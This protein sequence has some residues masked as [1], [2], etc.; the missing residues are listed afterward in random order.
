MRYGEIVRAVARTWLVLGAFLTVPLYAFDSGPEPSGDEGP[1]EARKVPPWG[2]DFTAP[3]SPPNEHAM[4]F[5]LALA[6]SGLPNTLDVTPSNP[7]RATT[8]S[9]GS[10]IDGGMTSLVPSALNMATT[11]NIRS[12]T[13]AGFAS[14]PDHSY[15]LGDWASGNEL[16]PPGTA[17]FN[18]GAHECHSFTKHLGPVNSTHFPPQADSMY[19][20][21][22]SLAL[23][24]AGAC[25]ELANRFT[26]STLSSENRIEAV[27]MVREC[28]REA[29][30]LEA[31]GQHFLQ[32]AWAIG[33]MWERWGYASIYDFTSA[34]PITPVADSSRWL[35]AV[36][37]AAVSGTIHGAEGLTKIPDFLSAGQDPA[38]TW[39]AANAT[40][41]SGMG[42]GDLHLDALLTDDAY[43]L[44]RSSLLNCSASGMREVYEQTA[45]FSSDPVGGALDAFTGERVDP[46]SSRCFGQRANNSAMFQA[47]FIRCPDKFINNPATSVAQVAACLATDIAIQTKDVRDYATV[48]LSS[49]ISVVKTPFLGQVQFP[50]NSI[51]PELLATARRDLIRAS[52]WG[53][54]RAKQEPGGTDLATHAFAV[55]DPEG[56][57]VG[58]NGFLGVERNS[59]AIKRNP[60]GPYVDPGFPW[61]GDVNTGGEWTPGKWLARTFH[62]S[63]VVDWC[64]H[65]EAAPSTLVE[66]VAQAP[67]AEKATACEVCTEFVR[68]H[69]QLTNN[70]DN[71][72]CNAAGDLTNPIIMPPSEVDISGAAKKYCKCADDWDPARDFSATRNPAP[73]WTYGWEFNYANFRTFPSMSAQEGTNGWREPLH[74]TSGAPSIIRAHGNE[75]VI[76]HPAPTIG[77]PVGTVSF[78]PTE[79][80]L[81]P[82][83]ETIP[84]FFPPTYRPLYAMLRFTAPEAGSYL[85][86]A[87]FSSRNSVGATTQVGV[88]ATRAGVSPLWVLK[89]E[90]ISS[91]KPSA[92]MPQAQ[93]IELKKGDVIDFIVGPAKDGERL[94]INSMFYDSTGLNA[95]I[96]LVRPS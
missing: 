87:T 58:P 73:P 88:L 14:L 83:V 25:R 31:V 57:E 80:V 11:T 34:S 21:Y 89:F 78:F 70:A 19:R 26:A 63:H 86:T 7:F 30:A 4:L 23:M 5:R 85:V 54:L 18:F 79:V 94:T 91:A 42:I 38:V 49:L 28:E 35:T 81:H 44:Q 93:V 76:T 27:G 92:S 37:T 39:S 66:R 84:S 10:A 33:H 95:Q 13:L 69:V 56:K 45:R 96:R 6:R 68:R 43:T 15:S 48:F 2:Y 8:F 82:A 32:D 36:I 52:V 40:G 72:L 55:T 59:I 61:P 75:L 22:H 53:E 60:P 16:C 47:L 9:I 3:Q 17:V 29:L 71:S 77:Q 46:V 12:Y 64:G 24:R 67:A 20:W 74:E 1:A 62:K 90:E 51:P 50:Q 41:P 65:N